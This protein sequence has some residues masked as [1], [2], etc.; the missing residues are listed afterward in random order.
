[1]AGGWRGWLKLLKQAG[2]EFMSNDCMR[3]AAALSYYTVFALPPLLILI[4]LVTSTVWDAREVEAAIHRQASG[5]VGVQAATEVGNM[6]QQADRPGTGGPL[7]TVLSVGALL[8]GATGAFFQLQESLN[9]AW[10]VQPDP[11]KG[12]IRNFLT[13]R[14][15]SLGMI[16]GVAFLLLVSLA[17]SALLSALGDRLAAMAPGVSEALLQALNA[18]ISFAV[19]ALLF[20]VIFKVMPDARIRWR[21]VWVGAVATAVLFVIGKFAIGFYLGSSDPGSAYGAAGSLAVILLWIYY[22]AIIVLFGAEFTKAWAELRG[23]GIRAEAG[24]TRVAETKRR[25]PDQPERA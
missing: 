9:R 2:G 23:S 24:A 5:L 19:I 17:V 15:V 18:G 7:A 14:L 1:M 11:A 20:A 4:I 13:K 25:V 22:A 10:H 6:I 8:F 12:G 3:M 16:L 21:D